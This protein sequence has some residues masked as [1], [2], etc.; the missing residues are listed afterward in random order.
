[1]MTTQSS[2]F[3][4]DTTNVDFAYI[5][6]SGMIR[7][8]SVRPKFIVT[9]K[10]DPVENVVVDFSTIKKSLKAAI[11]DKEEGY[12]HK[13]WWYADHSGGDLTIT[14]GRVVIDTPY[15]RIE[16]PR[17]ALTL[18]TPDEGFQEYVTRKAREA[19]PNVDVSID[20]KMTTTFDLMPQ[21]TSSAHPF[22]YVHGLRESTSWGCQNIGHGHLS[23]LAAD[24]TGHTAEVDDVLSQIA[25]EIHDTVF[26]WADNFKDDTITYTCSRG[27]MSMTLKEGVKRAVLDT[28]TTVEHLVDYVANTYRER[29][30]SVGVTSLFVS[31]GLSKG[32]CVDIH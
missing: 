31:E 8:G 9:G 3:L 18:I 13:L 16:I 10:V 17:N 19:Y 20:T 12:D 6:D 27:P 29:L 26:V 14:D 23:Y 5:D 24:A 25:T 15:V 21:M 22:R 4:G 32:A 1:M 28:E 7:G 30:L 2:L 11:D